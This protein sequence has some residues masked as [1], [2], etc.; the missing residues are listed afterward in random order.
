MDRRIAIPVVLVVFSLLVSGLPL[1]GV[2]LS[3]RS[4][5]LFVSFPPLT[6][7]AV[8]RP[9]SWLVFLL[10]FIPSAGVIALITAAARRKSIGAESVSSEAKRNLP[11]WGWVA[12]AVLLVSWFFA[13]TRFDWFESYQRLTFIPLWFS[14]IVMINAL[15]VR[16]AGTCPLLHEPVFFACLFPVSAVFWWL[17]EYL[18]Q[19]V[20][21][22]F[23][24]GVDYGPLAYSLHA[25][26]SF[27][28]VL[29]A[30][31]TTS[32]WIS[33][34]KWF[35][36][37]FHGLP[38]IR[39]LPV[40]FLNR[41]ALFI[42]CAGLIGV[43]L[44][45]EELFALLWLAPL[46][47]LTSLQH[48][49]GQPTLFTALAGGDWRPAV[50]A[51]IAALLCGFFWEMWNFYSL[52]KWIY[53]IPSVYRFKIFEMPLL[54]YMGYLPFGLLCLEVTKILKA[55]VLRLD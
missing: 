14:Y 25:T 32:L 36:N 15:C 2:Y 3:G 42:S 40:K 19:F 10:Y 26:I 18:N 22:W 48:I 44:W 52:A 16:Q 24:T 12:L 49:A 41:T 11:W 47:I 23:Y 27:S 8:H 34:L 50:S 9:F 39:R 1:L 45:P 28:T 6:I 4:T 5:D 53:S 38:S 46:L 13:W 55:V 43:G 7:P 51:A 29:P 20:Q 35:G 21:N 54:G 30:V 33:S 17:F 37:R 31:Y